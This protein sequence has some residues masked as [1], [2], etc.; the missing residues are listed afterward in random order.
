MAISSS[1]KWWAMLGIGLGT[2]M[3]TLDTSIVNVSLTTLERELHAEFETIQW[4]ILSYLLVTTSMMLVMARLG[5]MLGKRPIYRTGLTLFTF[6]SLLSGLSPS[7]EWLIGFRALQGLGGVMMFALGT[8]IITEIFPPEERGRALGIIGG[9]VSV[10]IATGP[11]LGGILIGSVG[12]RSIFLVNVPVGIIAF[13]IVRQVLPGAEP[14]EAR[15]RFDI[16]GA[17][18]LLITLAAYALGMTLG[19][20][21]GFDRSETLGLLALAGMGLPTFLMIELRTRQPMIDLRLFR[22]TLFGINLLMG[23][24][25]FILIG[26]WFLIP[27]YLDLVMGYSP[28]TVGLLM[29][30][31]PIA[32]GLTAPL[33]GALSDRFGPRVISL[34]GLIMIAAA[35][36]LISTSNEAVGIPGYI[37]RIAP[38]GIGMGM[39]NSPNNSA[40]MGAAPRD[41]LGVASGLLALSRSLGQTSGLPLIG[42]LFGVYVHLAANLAPGAEVTEAPPAA[43]VVGMA[44]T[45]RVAALFVVTATILAGIALW[46]DQRNQRAMRATTPESAAGE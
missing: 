4:V 20:E 10:G 31:F 43:L 17:A 40:V 6:A 12:W 41:R 22:N 29:T 44:G 18:I 7:V 36:L 23:F 9:I 28:Q 5:D 16:P 8:A 14:A 39:F 45:F 27:I 33:S 37:L 26:G 46:I 21:I 15:Q 25:V 11:A 1:R 3:S 42:A 13:F 24:L 38:L 32:M 2:F 19:Q 30:A 35:A 34:L